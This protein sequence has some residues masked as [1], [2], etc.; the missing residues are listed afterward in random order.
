[1]EMQANAQEEALDTRRHADAEFFEELQHHRFEL[2]IAKD[3]AL[4]DVRKEFQ[5]RLEELAENAAEVIDDA[6]AT[7]RGHADEIYD[8]TSARLRCAVVAPTRTMLLENVIEEQR[9]RRT[10][11]ERHTKI[12][13]A[14]SLPL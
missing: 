1:M 5:S 3:D 10:G 4:A 13:R 12:S 11:Q 14:S 7:M 9:R 6:D 2:E 8:E